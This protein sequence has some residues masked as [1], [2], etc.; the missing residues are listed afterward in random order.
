MRSEEKARREFLKRAGMAGAAIP[1]ARAGKV[2]A[3]PDRSRM[4]SVPLSSMM[5]GRLG[6]RATER[7]LTLLQSIGRLKK[8]PRLGAGPFT[9][10]PELTF[11]TRFI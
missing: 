5:F 3:W 4:G 7:Q 11:L 10:V 9:F 6:L 2:P 1:L 8:R